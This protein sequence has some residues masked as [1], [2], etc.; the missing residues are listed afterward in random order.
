MS[1]L[2]RTRQE[3][4]DPRACKQTKHDGT[5]IPTVQNLNFKTNHPPQQSHVPT[6]TPDGPIHIRYPQD[7]SC[8]FGHW[9]TGHLCIER[10]GHRADLQ[11]RS[12]RE[13]VFSFQ[14]G[15]SEFQDCVLLCGASVQDF[16]VVREATFKRRI[17]SLIG[18]VRFNPAVRSM[19]IT[20]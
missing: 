11:A 6:E 18:E 5:R 3:D 20:R 17:T 13:G 4:V 2:R 9:P 8:D 19:S 15:T 14:R 16:S 7:A 1:I 10:R 12:Q